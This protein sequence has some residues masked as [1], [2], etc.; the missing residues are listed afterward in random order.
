MATK[1]EGTQFIVHLQGIKLP[2]EVEAEI[3]KE[4]RSAAL[5]ELARVDLRG[6]LTLRIPRKE[7]LGIWLE[8]ISPID[9]PNPGPMG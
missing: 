6:D 3:A 5:R 2:A 8:R 7:W 9:L 1:Q 4:V